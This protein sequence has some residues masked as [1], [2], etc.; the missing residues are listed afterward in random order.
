[1]GILKYHLYDIDR[2]ISRTL[3]NAIVTCCDGHRPDLMTASRQIPCGR[4][5]LGTW[6][7]LV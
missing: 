4:P 2:I 6:C 3:A 1:L 7:G 5:H